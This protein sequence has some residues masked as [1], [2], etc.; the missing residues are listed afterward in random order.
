MLSREEYVKAARLEL[1]TKFHHQGRLPGVGLDCV[2]LV[3][4][5]C[6]QCGIPLRDF[7]AYRRIPDG[8][9]L[10]R[11][12]A[13]Q[14][15][16]VDDMQPADVICFRMGAHPRHVAIATD[17]GIIHTN[18]IIGKVVEHGFDE[19]WKSRA[20]AVFRFRGVF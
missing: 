16:R 9:T 7:G 18:G 10:M 2:G 15:D 14:L 17:Y 11:E 19:Y 1:G 8:V 4:V 5:T 12:I 6:K 3:V 13:A 20:M